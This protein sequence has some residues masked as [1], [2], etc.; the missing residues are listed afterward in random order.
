M[1]L[2]MNLEGIVLSEIRQTQKDNYCDFNYTWN[3][4]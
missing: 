1:T 4:K 2:W 3:L